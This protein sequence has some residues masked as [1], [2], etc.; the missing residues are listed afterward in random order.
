[1]HGREVLV[2]DAVLYELE[3]VHVHG[4][5]VVLAAISEITTV[6]LRHSFRTI[7][8]FGGCARIEVVVSVVEADP[9]VQLLGGPGRGPVTRLGPLVLRHPNHASFS[10]DSPSVE[11]ALDTTVAHGTIGEVCSHVWAVRT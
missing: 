9:S 11:G 8:W 2:V 1:M 4:P 6:D 5:R 7:S 10:I 3:Q